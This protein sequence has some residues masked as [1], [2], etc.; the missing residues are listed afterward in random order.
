MPIPIIAPE[1]TCVI[2]MGRPSIAPGPT[3]RD[4]IRLAMN[5]SLWSMG[6]I[7]SAKTVVI[8]RPACKLP[9]RIAIAISRY[10]KNEVSDEELERAAAAI[11]S[12][13]ILGASF[14]PRAKLAVALVNPWR[15]SKGSQK[16]REGGAAASSARQAT[17]P[18]TGSEGAV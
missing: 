13:T 18:I 15:L 5:P 10:T 1:A 12:A 16:T 14:K 7:R 8:R 11:T 9:A 3:K 2:D 17:R 6:V 4:V